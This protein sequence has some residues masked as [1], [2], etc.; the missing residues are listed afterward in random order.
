MSDLDKRNAEAMH[1]ASEAREARV[2]KL[3]TLVHA[4]AAQIAN[5]RAELSTLQQRF[6]VVFAT[7]RGSGPT[8]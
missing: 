6:A 2:A 3:E 4:Q 5:L 1:T 8:A 7:G